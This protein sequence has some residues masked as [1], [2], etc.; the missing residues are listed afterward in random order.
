MELKNILSTYL[1]FY[2]SFQNVEIVILI[3]RD[4]YY[5]YG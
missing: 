2:E 3:I 4:H 1:F 5:D